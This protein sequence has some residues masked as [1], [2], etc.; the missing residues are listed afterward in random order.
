MLCQVRSH[1]LDI[2]IDA[3][4][5]IKFVV[6]QKRFGLGVC[7]NV[8]VYA[9]AETDCVPSSINT[10]TN[11]FSSIITLSSHDRL[12]KKMTKLPKLLFKHKFQI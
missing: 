2:V 12:K 1:A 6:V 3:H 10:F 7:G 4:Q 8:H 11:L 9:C 5:H